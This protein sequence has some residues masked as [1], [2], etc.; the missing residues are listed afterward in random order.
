MFVRASKKADGLIWLGKSR[1]S[2]KDI[3]GHQR[4]KVA[5]MGHWSQGQSEAVSEVL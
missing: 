3:R 1:M 4:I 5:D 2:G